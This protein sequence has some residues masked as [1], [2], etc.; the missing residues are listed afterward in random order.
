VF[1]GIAET[2]RAFPQPERVCERRGV[3]RFTIE[4]YAFVRHEDVVENHEAFR[5]VDLAADRIMAHVFARGAYVMS[6]IDTPRALTG[7]A[8]A[9]A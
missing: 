8:H 9:I 6:M 4:E 2:G 5:A 1:P 3:R 7:T